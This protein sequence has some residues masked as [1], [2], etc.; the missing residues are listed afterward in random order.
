MARA[1]ANGA[2]SADPAS[3]SGRRS[4]SGLVNA[5]CHWEGSGHRSA[6]CRE[7]LLLNA[8][9]GADSLIQHQRPNRAKEPKDLASVQ[10]LASV[11]G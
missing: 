5:L 7:I 6:Y 3:N 11:H 9:G 8:P 1:K 2:K 4:P 10:L